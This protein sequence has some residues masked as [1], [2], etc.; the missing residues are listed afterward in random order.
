MLSDGAVANGRVEMTR[1]RQS[2]GEREQ[3]EKA[4][5]LGVERTPAWLLRR[6][7]SC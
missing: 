4:M 2:D 1:P 5:E 3:K 7:I 6:E